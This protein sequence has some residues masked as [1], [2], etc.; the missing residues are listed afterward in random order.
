V[1]HS[2]GHGLLAVVTSIPIYKAMQSAAVNTVSPVKSAKTKYHRATPTLRPMTPTP[3]QRASPREEAPQPK[4]PMLVFLGL[5]FQVI[6]VLHVYR[7]H[8][9]ISSSIGFPP[10]KI[11]TVSFAAY[12]TRERR[13]FWRLLPPSV[14]ELVRRP[15]T[16][17]PA[18]NYPR[19][20]PR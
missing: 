3:L 20:S 14:M 15:A 13:F 8:R 6:Y 16:F 1:A 12:H 7:S 18:S 2:L 10:A 4:Y 11:R 9:G 19:L 17:L 5:S